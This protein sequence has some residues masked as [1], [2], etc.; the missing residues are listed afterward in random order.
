MGLENQAK[1]ITRNQQ[2]LVNCSAQRRHDKI[3]IREQFEHYRLSKQTLERERDRQTDRQRQRE[4]ER[5]KV[6]H[7]DRQR[8]RQGVGP[9]CSP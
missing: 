2:R 5:D 8:Q 6:T 1:F 9:N 3:S 4:T 7:R